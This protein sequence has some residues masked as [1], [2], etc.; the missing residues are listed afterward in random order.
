MSITA[1][2]IVTASLWG[3]A[4]CCAALGLSAFARLA[5][6]DGGW[7]D[8]GCWYGPLIFASASLVLLT[9]A[10]AVAPVTGVFLAAVPLAVIAA[11]A[12][13]VLRAAVKA[14]MGGGKAARLVASLLWGRVRDALWNAREDLRDLAAAARPRRPEAPAPAPGAGIPPEAMA[15][16]RSVPSVREDGSLGRIPAVAEVA[17]GLEAAGV[18]VPPQWAAV[19]EW[20]AGFEAQDQEDLE[21]HMAQE[22]AGL[23]S[24]A[25]AAMTR[26]ETMLA[27]PKLH[28]AY[29][30][31]LLEVADQ[32]AEVAASAAMAARRYHGVY[33]DIED[34]H[35]DGNALPEDARAWFGGGNPAA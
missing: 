17:A 10:G 24:Y 18:A 23:L 32:L 30:A 21:E 25:E 4:A 3:A 12:S 34:W 6:T 31:A 35:E 13:R 16:L 15:V 9:A 27:V 29:V 28:P 1:S 19:A 8:A 7:R 22:T 5:R 2:L 20:A 33:G 14:G 11:R 26:A